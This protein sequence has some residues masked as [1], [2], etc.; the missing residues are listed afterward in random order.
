VSRLRYLNPFRLKAVARDVRHA[1]G[2][3]GPRLLR[4]THVR[5]PRGVIV[6]TA[7]LDFE[8]ESR[9]SRVT[10]FSTALPVPWP[11]AWGYRLAR[12]LSVPLVSDV[13]H[14][15]R[16]GLRVPLPRVPGL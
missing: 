8:V 4:L 10:R 14:E 16:L 6:P 13:D 3:G 5:E 7:V 15:A 2:G 12:L 9:D 1:A 11:F